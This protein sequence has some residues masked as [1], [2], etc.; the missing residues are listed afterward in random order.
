MTKLII[1]QIGK[2][3][4]LKEGAT[5]FHSKHGVAKLK[6]KDGVIT[7]HKDVDFLQTEANF[8]DKLLN[9]K[10]G[11]QVTLPKDAAAIVAH[12]SLKQGAKIVDAGTGS[13]WLVSFLARYIGPKGQITTYEKRKEFAEI[14]EHNFKSLGL[15]N[16][17]QKIGDITKGIK[18]KNVDL[19][20]LDLLT[21]TQ[22]PN[23]GQALKTGGYVV[24]YVPHLEQAEDFVRYSRDQNI[25]HEKT[26]EII[27]RE[28]VYKKGKLKERIGAIGHTAYLVFC[29]KI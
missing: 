29:R 8:L 14:A 23:V 25:W 7:S 3:Y 9:C 2:K 27:E 26:I 17:K 4:L 10:R 5:E 13:G 19:I 6:K 12:T 18:E 24:A 28:W 22:I 21:P 16:I 1:D 15:K 11:P 20:T